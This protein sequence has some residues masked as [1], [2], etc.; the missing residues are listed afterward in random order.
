V[1]DA[2][3]ARRA[4]EAA[5][6]DALDPARS[7]LLQAPA[8]SGKTT[9]LAQR[10][11]RLLAVVDEP[12][13]ILAIT[14]TRK[15]AAEMRDRVLRALGAD[16]PGDDPVALRWRELR[17]AALANA[18]ARGWSLAELAGR[19]R[20]QTIDSVNQDIARSMPVLGRSEGSLDVVDDA[21]RLYHRAARRTLVDA[22]DLPGLAD[23]ADLLLARLDNQWGRVEQLVAEMLRDR[24]RWL[25]TLLS[26][27]PRQ[28]GEA[29]E[30]S[31][32]RIVGEALSRA[33]QVLGE[34]LL[35]EATAL[36]VASAAHRRREG[37]RAG[38]WESFLDASTPVGADP[39]T[40][41]A[42]QVVIDLLLTATD[43]VRKQITKKHGFPTTDKPLKARWTQWKDGLAG[44]DR[45]VTLLRELRRL[46]PP[47]IAQPERDAIAALARLLQLAVQEL[48][49]EFQAAGKV[50]HTEV[51]GTARAALVAAGEPSDLGLA[52]ASRLRHLLVDEFQDTSGEQFEL[53]RNLTTGWEPGDGRS[54]FLVGDP[55][56]SIYLFRSAEVGLFLRARD[57][58]IGR[59]R[60]E[61][62]ALTRNFRSLAPVVTWVNDCFARIFPAEEDL[63]RS[64]VRYLP[65]QAHRVV[66][67]PGP[68]VHVLGGDRQDAEGEPARVAERIAA[69]RRGQ[70]EARIAVLLQTR[71]F[72]APLLAAL[73]RHDVPTRG[74]ELEPLADQPAVRDLVSMA[75]AL[76]QAGDR[77]A[78]LALLRA[79]PCGLRLADLEAL[80][81]DDA[82]ALV[83]D[84]L[85]DAAYAARLGADG[86]A[87]LARCAPLIVQAWDRRGR[88]PLSMMLTRLWLQLGGPAA[89]ADEGEVAQARLFLEALRR[90]EADGDSPD[91]PDVLR[92]AESLRAGADAGGANP[93]E[94]LTIHHAKGL[95]WDIVFVPGLGREPRGDPATLLAWL[96]LP[97]PGGELDLLLSALSIGDPKG[98]SDALTRYIRALSAERQ[99][100]ERRRLAYVAATRA[101]RELYLSGCVA[102]DVEDGS[103]RPPSRSLL[104]LLWP[105]VGSQYALPGTTQ[106]APEA[107]PTQAAVGASV[108]QRPF[109][110]LPA[111]WQRPVL[112][113]RPGIDRVRV[114]AQPSDQRPEFS[115]VGRGARAAGTLVHAELERAASLGLADRA[116]LEARRPAFERALGELGLAGGEAA[117][118]ADRVITLLDSLRDEPTLAWILGGGHRDAANELRLTGLHDGRLRSISI[119]RSFVDARGDRWIIDYKTSAHEGA[120]LDAFVDE[121]VRRYR[122][123]LQLYR[124]LASGLGTEPVRT[125][126]YFPWLRRLREVEAD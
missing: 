79:P 18:A 21:M 26:T 92:L 114:G 97:G 96:Q 111:D 22:E 50:D 33:T 52:R 75:C 16:M 37:H 106:T 59:I 115:W 86:Q 95:E 24:A 54:I 28:L 4:D 41:P 39:A 74:L 35:A 124:A 64:A 32:R 5:R 125:A 112:R 29:V 7:M 3:D 14:F 83:I 47:V 20:I 48:R 9:V 94:I 43:D 99:Q 101:R 67:G 68:A 110:R 23:D 66:A 118:I 42:W 126:L 103:L 102:V 58:G 30:Q 119:D 51:A 69:V 40:L 98:S 62:R 49:I 72:A 70:P 11:L 65:A 107:G 109:R 2:D 89:S 91:G 123:Q 81:G 19:L 45:A 44:D 53:L 85:R 57:A 60:L 31:L 113:S 117:V 88:E 34:S 8:G 15:A 55:M 93:V 104:N 73:R 78:W 77:S 17:A 61:Y 82:D 105:A 6:L 10:H 63:R 13:E 12:E 122:G 87:R 76:R 25:P 100:N 56:Q 46:P 80:V 121:E 1:S 108:L 120:G 71:T 36:A 38:A 90:R 116:A 84:R 27:D